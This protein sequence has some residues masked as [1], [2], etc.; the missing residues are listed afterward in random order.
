[1]LG[2]QGDAPLELF[3]GGQILRISPS[4]VVVF[5]EN[6]L[7]VGPEASVERALKAVR[8]QD[9]AVAKVVRP[10]AVGPAAVLSFSLDGPGYGPVASANGALEL[11][12][13]HLG[14][15]A[16]AGLGSAAEAS[17]LA[18][19][20]RAGLDD[21]AAEVGAAPDGV[22]EAVK[23]YLSRIHITANGARLQVEMELPGGAEAQSQLIGTLSGAGIY[24][25]RQY[26]A[27][28]KLAEAKNTVGAI[29]RTLVTHM[30]MEN[31][32]GKR[33]TRFPRSAP[34]TPAKVPT[35][36]LFVP[37][38]TT[39]SH[40]T[41][42]A[43]HFEMPMPLY[44]SYEI[45]TSKDGRTATVRAHGDLDGDGKLSTIERTLTLEKD[46]AVVTAAKLVL[47]DELE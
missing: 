26:L 30:E 23:G 1:M 15:R 21:A 29:A 24:A 5:A 7:F 3:E 22:G 35:G 19:T 9:G 42:Q 14:L 32:T 27:Q 31:E 12:A 18:Q 47:Q 34:P 44:Y 25:V 13:S 37:D 45:I 40:P 6:L 43:L 36:V 4:R 28:S 41:W 8:R 33:P 2:A 20:M 16:V 46:G 10:L 39:W 17:S 11:D 38:A